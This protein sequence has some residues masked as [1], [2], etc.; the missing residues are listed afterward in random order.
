[1]LFIV[2]LADQLKNFFFNKDHIMS[3][4]NVAGFHCSKS[5]I[6]SQ[7]LYSSFSENVLNIS[8]HAFAIPFTLIGS[9]DGTMDRSHQT[10]R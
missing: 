9:G 5:P 7:L 6:I 8:I 2:Q 3:D 1:M 4:H 10:L